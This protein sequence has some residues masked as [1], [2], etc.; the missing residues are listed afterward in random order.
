M[1]FYEDPLIPTFDVQIDTF[2]SPLFRKVKTKNTSTDGTISDT[3]AAP[4]QYL[5]VYY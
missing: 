4:V 3:C 5:R 2:T 1:F